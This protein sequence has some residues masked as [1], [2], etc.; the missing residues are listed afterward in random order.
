VKRLVIELLLAGMVVLALAFA[1]T[2]GA[3]WITP[4]VT[5]G[6]V[7]EKA[8]PYV[9]HK[10]MLLISVT[11]Y[12]DRPP[13]IVDLALLPEGRA[14]PSSGGQDT[15]D[16]VDERG[17]VVYTFAFVPDFQST[18]IGAEEVT[19]VSYSFVLPYDNRA[20]KVV[21]TTAAGQTSQLLP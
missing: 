1:L 4:P 8:L 11:I 12:K 18:A 13:V 9:T 7:E 14:S 20:Q 19:E 16:L 5:P 21:V 2:G 6:T 10:E 15:I 3:G 17:Q